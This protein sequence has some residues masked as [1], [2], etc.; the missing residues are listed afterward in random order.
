[1]LA[2]SKRL[3]YAFSNKT[4]TFGQK[5]EGAS[6]S[7][8]IV[9]FAKTRK[10]PFNIK[11]ES[12][13]NAYLSNGRSGP[14]TLEL[15]KTN[16]IA[17]VDIPDAEYGDHVVEAKI[18]IDSL[19][20]YAAA[21]VM[22]HAEDEGSYY[23][24]LVSSKGYFRVD[25]VKENNPKALIAWTEISDFNGA[26][27]NLKIITCGTYLIFF[28]NDKWVG[29]TSDDTINSGY[30]GFA[31]ASYAAGDAQQE[32]NECTCK[33]W[34]DYFSVDTRIKVIEEQF[35]KW[36]ENPN[37]NAEGRLRLAETF[38]VMGK[39]SKALEQI[40]KTWEQ[41]DEVIRSATVSYT[42][43]RTRKELLLA[44][45]MSFSLGQYGEAEE[46]LDKILELWPS[47]AEGKV[48]CKEML[49]VLNELNKFK[50]L[51]EF[52]KKHSGILEKDLDY[53]AITA[54][55]YWELKEYKNS[56][57]AWK[58]AFMKNKENGVYAANAANALELAGNN[59]KA[60]PLFLAAGKIFLNQGNNA[61]LEAM[62]P[63]LSALGSDN[64]EARALI[65]KWAFGIGD[66][67]RCEAEFAA[68]EKNRRALTPR[69]NE[70]PAL[71]YLRGLVYN[72]K[73]KI[74]AAVRLLERAVKLAPGYGLFRFKLAEI[75]L[76]N[77][78]D[79]PNLVSELKRALDSIDG[80]MKAEMAK[81][82]GNLLLNAG[83]AENA[84]YFL[85]VAGSGAADNGTAKTE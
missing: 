1:M 28:V 69:P 78:I 82:A 47:S 73:G 41:R 10:S 55:C 59:E 33:A 71:N 12:S 67:N 66:Y 58:N 85:A 74:D 65:G 21:G 34:L 3:I 17:W 54:R 45:R 44:A 8:L 16:C 15:K 26:N 43:V 77:G 18:R 60:L 23:L 7:K 62:I 13:Y 40:K 9:D 76:T 35:T 19:G 5:D 6:E 57:S 24:A 29:E 46:F 25:V 70:D 11:S 36:T 81:H 83:D 80:D 20:G 68:A 39:P 51:K 22:F 48:A 31:L 38:A 37:I 2:F 42:E 63:K 53:Y 14:L 79:D 64:W 61:E 84:Q 50:E 4:R 56:A 49:K 72:I 32:T 27:I 52:V 30:A 75:K